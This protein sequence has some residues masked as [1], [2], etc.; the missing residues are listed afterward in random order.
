MPPLSSS[1]HHQLPWILGLFQALGVPVAP[2][3]NEGPV[4]EVTF[5]GIVVDTVRGELCLP[6]YKIDETQAKLE[7]WLRRRSRPFKEYKAL[8][9]HLSHAATVI[10]QGCIFLRH[11]YVIMKSTSSWRHYVH[12]DGEARADLRWWHCLLNHWNGF[13]FFRQTTVPA[14]LVYS[15]ASGS[16]G[17]GGVILPSH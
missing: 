12:L 17:C 2:H 14:A 15:D 5:L 3:K 9:G 4:T 1:L 13:M 7:W 8:V 16:F 11:L 10:Y 6:S